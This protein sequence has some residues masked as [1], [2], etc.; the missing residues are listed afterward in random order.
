MAIKLRRTLFIGLGGTGIDTLLHIKR[1]LVDTYGATI[2]PMIGFIGVDTDNTSGGFQKTKKTTL[3][4]YDTVQLD[5]SEQCAITVSNP[6]DIYLR[7][8]K[9][10]G[11]MP[12]KNADCLLNL[13]KGA[14]Q[15]RTNGRFA[16]LCNTDKF[17]TILQVQLNKIKDSTIIDKQKYSLIDND[18]EIYVIGSI[19]GGT[20]C[21]TFIDIGYLI[22]KHFESTKDRRY[23]LCANLF[24][25]HVYK[26]MLGMDPTNPQ[27]ANMYPNAYAALNDLDFL[28][29]TSMQNPVY[30][31]YASGEEFFDTPPYHTVTLIDNSDRNGFTYDHINKLE[32]MAAV[33]LSL[34]IGD[35]GDTSSMMDNVLTYVSTGQMDIQGK[36][37]W[38]SGMGVCE[39]AIDGN[40]LANIYAYRYGY[41][42][43]QGIINTCDDTIAIANNWID[44]PNIN[45]REN[46]GDENN[47]LIDQIL[48][49]QLL[50]FT[51]GDIS[52]MDAEISTYLLRNEV[53]KEGLHSKTKDFCQRLPNELDSLILTHLNRECG[54]GNVLGILSALQ[55]EIGL[56]LS[57]MVSELE[58]HS[59]RTESLE[60]M[61]K[62]SKQDLIAI[63]GSFMPFSKRSRLNEAR[64][65]LEAV[66]YDLAVN[67]LEIARKNE[68][69]IIFSLLYEYLMSKEREYK[70]LKSKIESILSD[71]N[72]QTSYLINKKNDSDKEFIIELMGNYARKVE[73]KDSELDYPKFFKELCR[74][75]EDGLSDLMSMDLKTISR[76]FFDIALRSDK[77]LMWRNIQVEKALTELSK[78]ERVKIFERAVQKSN[79]LLNYDH[80]GYSLNPSLSSTF[81]VGLRDKNSSIVVDEK[82][83][84]NLISGANDKVSY[85][86]TN[87]ENS[88]VIYRQLF[89]L[90]AF[91]LTPFDA[92]ESEYTSKTAEGAFFH[93]DSDLRLKMDKA[94]YSINPKENESLDIVELWVQAILHKFIVNNNG[95][96][97]IKSKSKGDPLDGYWVTLAQDNYRDDAF[98]EFSRGIDLYI[99][100]LQTGINDLVKK[101]GDDVYQEFL[102]KIRNGEPSTELAYYNNYSQ[103]GIVM[104]ELKENRNYVRIADLIRDEFNCLN[105][106][107]EN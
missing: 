74:K 24:L 13:E 34:T 17:K 40:A 68:A 27:T 28:M 86:S 87:M 8:K 57:E 95:T 66:V 15:V 61:I 67:K 47:N 4:D 22:R 59:K 58:E 54:V 43:I 52:S 83:V 93:I 12:S 5:A 20:G 9:E 75:N 3:A 33:S 78:E 99:D 97:Q 39:I 81:V 11:W 69:K 41:R 98:D 29:H 16:L 91:S 49:I 35:F 62:A 42:I 53:K 23:K 90:P 19:A 48:P 45:I 2:P 64:Q 105:L 71:Y 76:K 60:S 63:N 46:N 89:A 1:R 79:I 26:Q 96:Y 18:V 88:I 70:N 32:E 25:P 51:L 36:K 94:A 50:P 106:F 80:K 101:M 84:E 103:T 102:S 77:A 82:L 38:A 7:N 73:V 92:C 100:E 56:Y 14:G 6:K 10:F 37:S 85:T 104:S 30:L 31:S 107:L 21:G 72:D 55:K 44:S 65:D